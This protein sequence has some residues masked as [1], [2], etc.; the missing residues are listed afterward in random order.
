MVVIPAGSFRMGD[1]QGDGDGDEKP[2]HAV[3]IPRPF[4]V[5]R[6]EVTQ[7]EWRAVMGTSPSNFKGERNPVERVGWNDAKEFARKL[8]AMTGKEYRLLSEAEWEYIA[9]AGSSTRY[10]WG[11]NISSR[12][13]KLGSRNG[14]VPVGSYAANA[15]GVFDTVGNAWEWVEDCWHDSYGG[16]PTDGGAWTTGD[17]CGRRVL[18]G[19][20]W[21]SGH[22]FVRTANRIGNHAD[23]RVSVNGFRIA[24]TLSR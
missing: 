21:V 17:N 19:G 10:P 1:L 8:S 12:Q 16:A 9:R 3:T 7:A 4:A 20:S 11:K 18:R 14:T 22:R 5:G 2:V 13:A 23:F 24:R 6:Y 15:F